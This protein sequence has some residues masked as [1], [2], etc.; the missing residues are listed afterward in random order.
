[1]SSGEQ[2]LRKKKFLVFAL[3]GEKYC[4]PL[5][6]IKE[7]IDVVEITPVPQVP[8]FF[9]GLI[10]LRGQIISVIDLR[11][12]FG[13]TDE[14]SDPKKTCIIITQVDDLV[15][16]GIVDEVLEVVGYDDNDINRSVEIKTP[17]SGKA[18]SG[19]AKTK[20]GDLTLLVDIK[21]A[22][23]VEEFMVLKEKAA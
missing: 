5:S 3:E 21:K 23:G 13:F 4:L 14:K 7:V 22:L 19:V 15:L 6:L 2:A 10:N 20:E 1:M 11:T 12:K 9:K 16:G 17:G 18:V 8:K